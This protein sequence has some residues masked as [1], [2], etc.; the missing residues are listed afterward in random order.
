MTNTSKDAFVVLY[1][2]IIALTEST[3]V[4]QFNLRP[5]FMFVFD[6]NVPQINDN[7]STTAENHTNNE[8]NAREKDKE[9]KTEKKKNQR[10]RQDTTRKTFKGR[11]PL[12]LPF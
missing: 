12:W 8:I 10:A 1:M 11:S 2:I 5:F 7:N 3:Q 4:H 6:T 9:K